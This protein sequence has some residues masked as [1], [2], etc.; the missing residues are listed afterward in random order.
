[1]KAHQILM[2]RPHI[3]IKHRYPVRYTNLFMVV[4]LKARA[5]RN[6]NTVNLKKSAPSMVNSQIAS[7]FSKNLQKPLSVG[8]ASKSITIKM[9]RLRVTKK[10]SQRNM[11]TTLRRLD[12]SY[13]TVL[14]MVL[15]LIQ[16][17]G[18]NLLLSL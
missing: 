8:R 16:F 1:M 4:G 17:V 11:S 9:V 2:E 3:F 14:P 6:A 15:T 12:N 5:P 10:A 13:L 18:L 7:T